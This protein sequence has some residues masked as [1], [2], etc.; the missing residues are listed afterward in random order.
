MRQPIS[1]E[2]SMWTLKWDRLSSADNL[3]GRL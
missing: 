3:F 1:M 2:D